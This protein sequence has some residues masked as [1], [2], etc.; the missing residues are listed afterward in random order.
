MANFYLYTEQAY[1]ESWSKDVRN[2]LVIVFISIWSVA[3]YI[4]LFLGSFTPM[5]C[6]CVLAFAGIA[7]VIL[8]FFSGFGLLYYCGV[9][10]SNFHSWL[11]FLSMAIGVEHIFVICTAVD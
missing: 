2:D 7:S 11:P 6:R 9:K 4:M 10:T 8:S 3:L 5:H 1:V